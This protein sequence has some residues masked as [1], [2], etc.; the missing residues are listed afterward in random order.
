MRKL[1][2]IGLIV[3]S[4]FL[5]VGLANRA[6]A[7]VGDVTFQLSFEDQSVDQTPLAYRNVNVYNGDYE[8]KSS[9]FDLYPYGVEGR[10]RH[11]LLA[12]VKTDGH[13]KF[14]LDVS[15]YNAKKI[16][17]RVGPTYRLIVLEKSSDIS[18]TPSDRHLRVI[19][20]EP[21]SS[22]VNHND[23]YDL[24]SD[25]LKTIGMDGSIQERRFKHIELKVQKE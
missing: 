23:I 11:W 1:F 12:E 21:G 17:L 9:T 7:G 8:F 3:F 14:N 22:R 10:K 15:R 16:F 13:G 25:R 18:H 4:S 2:N 24:K 5:V 19:G 6:F 20:F